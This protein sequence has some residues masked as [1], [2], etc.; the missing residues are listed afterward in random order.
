M[1]AK[2]K[3]NKKN[4]LAYFPTTMTRVSPFFP[5]P[6]GLTDKER[7]ID[8]YY[9]IAHSWGVAKVY[10]YKLSIYDEDILY[11]LLYIMEKNKSE[12]FV[13]TRHEIAKILEKNV[14]AKSLSAIWKSLKR[15][16]LTGMELSTWKDTKSGR[17]LVPYY[18]A[19]LLA[20]ADKDKEPNKIHVTINPYFKEMVEKRLITR[21]DIRF[22]STL[23]GDIAKALHRFFSSQ[24]SMYVGTLKYV[25][26]LPKL[27]NA[28]N[29]KV[30]GIPLYQIRRQMR[31]ALDHLVE[32]EYLESH[33][34]E[35]DIIFVQ[36]KKKEKIPK[37]E[38]SK[39]YAELPNTLSKEIHRLWTV[40][41][42][43]VQ[44]TKRQNYTNIVTA[45]EKLAAFGIKYKKRLIPSAR[46]PKALAELAFKALKKK[47]PNQR[48]IHTG[49]LVMDFFYESTLKEY[50]SSNDYLGE[51]NYSN[52][53]MYN[54]ESKQDTGSGLR[55]DNGDLIP[56]SRV[57]RK[58]EK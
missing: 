25:I 14:G 19:T 22:R 39:L 27:C 43:K 4:I 42:P 9:E 5:L 3:A 44:L 53:S 35:K 1:T 46:G 57:V 33:K 10:G 30:Q 51:K 38:K 41:Y 11:G 49:Y 8:G 28:I 45:M 54:Y 18:V 40:H 47:T 24:R 29:L 13:T 32:R 55:D 2:A 16:T 50:L 52:W 23:R 58:V 48:Q 15:L 6:K 34:I 17:K 12:C 56:E 26:Q 7:Q 31:K 36:K 21:I 20:G 37:S